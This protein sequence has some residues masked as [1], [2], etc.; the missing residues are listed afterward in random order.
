[1]QFLRADINSSSEFFDLFPTMNVVFQYVDLDNKEWLYKTHC[2][3][4]FGPLMQ[5]LQFFQLSGCLLTQIDVFQY[6]DEEGVLKIPLFAEFAVS[7]NTQLN[8][9]RCTAKSYNFGYLGRFR[10]DKAGGTGW[11]VASFAPVL[12]N[13]AMK[14][15]YSKYHGCNPGGMGANV[16]GFIATA[17][18]A[19][20]HTPPVKR[21]CVSTPPPII[22]VIGEASLV[23]EPNVSYGFVNDTQID[24]ICYDSLCDDA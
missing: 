12:T 18:D 6:R 14:L 20:V 1:M 9:H 2:T 7:S 17:D 15:V 22:P 11:G 24:N 5:L 21:K 16:A 23:K 10:V 4:T 8:V 3:L 19:E 13:P